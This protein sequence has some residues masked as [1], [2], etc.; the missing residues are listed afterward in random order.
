[1][2]RAGIVA[3]AIL[4]V[5]ATTLYGFGGVCCCTDGPG[6]RVE[7]SGDPCGL[8]DHPRADSCHQITN[9]NCTCR[10][11]GEALKAIAPSELKS[12]TLQKSSQSLLV[13]EITQDVGF[14]SGGYPFTHLISTVKPHPMSVLLQTCS[15]LS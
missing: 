1:M 9:G 3:I 4:L 8:M 15:F 13:H 10:Q 2:S 5:W 6:V 11:C 12:V 7:A 14:G